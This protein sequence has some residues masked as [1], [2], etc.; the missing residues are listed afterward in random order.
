[1]KP[2]RSSNCPD[3]KRPILWVLLQN[4]RYRTMEPRPVLVRQHHPKD[5]PGCHD[6]RVNGAAG[7]CA[8]QVRGCRPYPYAGKLGQELAVPFAPREVTT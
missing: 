8:W 7:L 5:G 4:G 3:C 1:V 6:W 2:V